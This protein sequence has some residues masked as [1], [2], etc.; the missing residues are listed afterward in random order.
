V[1]IAAKPARRIHVAMQSAPGAL[2][3]TTTVLKIVLQIEVNPL[4]GGLERTAFVFTIGGLLHSIL[5]TGFVLTVGR[6][7]AYR[8]GCND[9]ANHSRRVLS[10]TNITTS[11]STPG[12]TVARLSQNS[13]VK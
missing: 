1:A 4:L 6:P 2:T 12:F 11:G 5:R 9:N 7:V 3:A 8:V 10:L 13:A